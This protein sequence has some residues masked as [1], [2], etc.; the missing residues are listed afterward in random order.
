L[1]GFSKKCKDVQVRAFGLG[2]GILKGLADNIRPA[3]RKGMFL[4]DVL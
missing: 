1:F 3:G 2:K 4:G